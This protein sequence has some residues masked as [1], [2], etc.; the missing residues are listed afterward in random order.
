VRT[1]VLIGLRGAGKSTVARALAPS[2]GVEAVDLDRAIVQHAGK[3]VADIFE[4]DGEASFREAESMVLESTLLRPCVLA[5]GGG[6]V[7]RETNRELIKRSGAFVVY[8]A[9]RPETLARR[10]EEDTET[11][12]PPLVPGGPLAEA[13]ALLAIREPFYEELAHLTIDTDGLTP[14]S[15]SDVIQA[16]LRSAPP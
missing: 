7:L 9:G 3:S 15:V 1:I 14:E 12:R 6:V 13:R 2:L 5:P 10:V 8:L 4:E 11:E 16:A